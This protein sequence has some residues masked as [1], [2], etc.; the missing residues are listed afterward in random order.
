MSD[1]PRHTIKHWTVITNTEIRKIQTNIASP[2]QTSWP[3]LRNL[4]KN[5]LLLTFKISPLKLSSDKNFWRIKK[6]STEEYSLQ[7]E[8]FNSVQRQSVEVTIPNACRTLQDIHM[9]NSTTW[10]TLFNR[11]MKIE[12]TV[13]E[14][15]QSI[16]LKFSLF[17]MFNTIPHGKFQ[18]RYGI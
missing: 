2:I 12:T 5:F 7:V 17:S 13:V 15:E 10:E 9:M 11:L 14:K 16:K 6:S 8:N 4:S 1:E 3:F 18:I